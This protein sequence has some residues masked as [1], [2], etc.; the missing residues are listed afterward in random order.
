MVL[1]VVGEVTTLPITVTHLLKTVVKGLS[2]PDGSA[3]PI[4]CL[5]P[6]VPVAGRLLHFQTF[7]DTIDAKK[8]V[9]DI[10]SKGYQIPFKKF[11]C[12]NSVRVTPIA[13]NYK[14]VL[15]EEVQ[16]LLQKHAIEEVL[17]QTQVG[18]YSMYFL[19]PKKTGDLRPILNLK[20]IN[21]TIHKTSFK[22]ETLQSIILSL[23]PNDWVV[24]IDLKDAYFHIPIHP[25][26]Y[27]YLR[28]A[29]GNQCFQYKVLPFG[30]TTSP[31]VFTKV[32]APVM[33]FLRQKGVQVYPYLDDILVVAES[34]SLLQQ[35]LELAMSVLMEAGYVINLKK[36]SLNPSQDS[37]FLGARFI[38]NLNL[39][40][41]PVSKAENLVQLTKAFR[42]GKYLKVRVWL[43][44]LGVMASTIFMV[45]KARLMQR[46]IQFFVNNHW[47]R[48]E[49]GLN[50]LI[51]VTRSLFQ[52]LTW[53]KNVDNLLLGLPLSPPQPRVVITTDASLRG[54]G[55]AIVEL[56]GVQVQ[57]VCQGTWSPQQSALHINLLEMKAVFLVLKF[58]LSHIVNKTVMVRSDNSTVCAYIN[59]MGGTKSLPLCQ[60]VTS[61]WNWCWDHNVDLRSLH[62]PGEDNVIADVLSRQPVQAREWSLH[63]R[64]VNTLFTMWD[65]PVIDLFA[66]IHNK[67][68][69]NYCSLYPD[70]NAYMQD[71]FTI[72]WARFSIAYA[73]PPPVILHRVLAKVR[74]DRARVILIAPN[75]P[76]RSWF[77]RILPL[78]VEVP[79]QLPLWPV[80]LSQNK[81]FTTIHNSCSW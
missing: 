48:K 78:L 80:L 68:I 10:V 27:K 75:W 81:F 41:L 8:W 62:I 50:H 28:F 14:K 57:M 63:H 52:A 23:Q 21:H 33:G 26:H 20:P 56:D 77:T 1:E 42:V 74:R 5:K 35:D 25:E 53:W 72:D 22:M 18:Y 15:L 59:K 4:A 76:Q 24:S 47:N 31:R 13:G 64:V 9:K 79:L 55:G 40:C 37:V 36:S 71:A 32:L 45:H 19:V 2:G 11:P 46:P 54:W 34:P 43:Q 69:A 49:Q 29:I 44:L 60:E 67:K 51:M 39:V 38:T 70:P 3:T 73:F 17:D 66:S 58:F 61:L 16:S 12:F 65:R 30:L 7:W 6:G